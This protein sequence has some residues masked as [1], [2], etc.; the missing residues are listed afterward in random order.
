M[1]YEGGAA[2]ISRDIDV[3]VK[4]IIMKNYFVL[5]RNQSGVRN[6]NIW[7]EIDFKLIQ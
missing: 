1:G 6:K 5:F 4:Y 3:C 7:R 2:E